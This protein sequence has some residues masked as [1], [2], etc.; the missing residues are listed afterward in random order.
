MRDLVVELF[1][2]H[3]DKTKSEGKRILQ[4]I[5]ELLPEM[6]P[7]FYNTYEPVNKKFDATQI[8]AALKEWH[9]SFL[10]KRKKPSVTGALFLGTAQVGRNE[11]THLIIRSKP[12]IIDTRRLGRFVLETSK[13][14][15]VDMGLVHVLTKPE[16]EAKRLFGLSSHILKES[17]PDL[18]WTTVF[19]PPYVKLFGKERL[20]STPA[21]V[22]QQLADDL[23]Y[24]QLT[25]DLMDTRKDPEGVE[26]SRQVAKR[27]L[28]SNAFLDTQR[29][30]NYA[31]HKPEFHIKEIG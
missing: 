13:A 23:V 25:N 15:Q 14:F 20:L 16:V 26:A 2:P 10:R 29:S 21:A 5:C 27:H 1:V 19:G 7:E 28:D 22:V 8:N 31:Y 17:L 3:V 24:I 12:E 6:M 18:Y 30:P 4:M 9:F 11:H